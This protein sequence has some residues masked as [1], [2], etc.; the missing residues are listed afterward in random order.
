MASTEAGAVENDTITHHLYFTPV[1]GSA[2]VQL[3]NTTMTATVGGM[4]PTPPNNTTTYLRGDGTFATPATGGT[5]TV[6]SASVTTANGVSGTVATATTTPAIT[7]SLGDITPSKVNTLYVDAR[8]AGSALGNNIWIGDGG[9]SS[10]GATAGQGSYNTV[11]GWSAGVLMSSSSFNTAYGFGSLGNQTTGGTVG[12][13]NT[14]VGSS[15]LGYISTGYNNVA[16]G[17]SA[18]AGIIGNGLGN[19][20]STNSV[21]IGANTVAAANGDDN[22]VVI[23]NAA[24]GNGSNTVTLGNSSV[25]KTVLNGQI[26]GI[27]YPYVAKTS[28]YTAT[29]TD[30]VIDCTATGTYNITLPTAIGNTG[31]IFIV[32]KSS[33]S[34][35]SVATSLSQTIDGATTYALTAQWSKVTV[36]SDGAN[37]KTL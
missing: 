3:D 27:E 34:T 5:G 35:T 36:V 37:W 10:S 11:A 16:I 31:K 7:L 13:N 25:T 17:G 12:G 29:L 6:T 24:I 30:M 19:Y 14:A 4:V 21:Y 33:T 8:K 18:G 9:R 20:T 32:K 28:A 22:E 2:R 15:S 23:G 1:A 26:V